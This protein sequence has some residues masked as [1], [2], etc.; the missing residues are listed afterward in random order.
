MARQIQR[1]E[2]KIVMEED[3]KQ[4]GQPGEGWTNGSRR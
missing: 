1:H 4:P 2:A 3:C